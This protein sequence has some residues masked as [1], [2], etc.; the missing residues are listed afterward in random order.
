MDCPH[1]LTV[2]MI[3]SFHQMCVLFSQAAAECGIN[4]SE[5]V[6]Q[7]NKHTQNIAA[8]EHDAAHSTAG[9]WPEMLS[10]S[11]QISPNETIFR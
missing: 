4:Y 5:A 8:I 1:F 3:L 11:I 9:R 6:D 7:H 2:H 10:H